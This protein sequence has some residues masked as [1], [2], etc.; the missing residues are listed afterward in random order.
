M[1]G[2]SVLFNK[3][4][5]TKENYID[6]LCSLKKINHRG[7]DDEGIVLIN[8]NTNDF[9]IIKNDLTLLSSDCVSDISSINIENYNLI[10]GHKR[11]SIIDL[12]SQ[13]H[14]PMQGVDGSW[15]VFNGEIYNYIELKEE[16][17]QY[18]CQFHTHSDTEVVL[19]AYRIWGKE[20]LNKFN[21]MW[22]ICIWDAPQKKLFINNDRFGVKP[23]Y[24][25]EH[26]NGF[27]LVSELKQFQGFNSVSLVLNKNHIEEFT[28]YGF[29]DV[30][31]N[32]MYENISRFKKSHYL[33]IDPLQYFNQDI[34][35]KQIPYYW[36]KKVAVEISEKEAIEQFRS[37]L[38]D[39]VR[40]RMRADVD[41]GFALSGGI[42][43]S[44]VLYMARNI[45]KDNNMMNELLGF[46]AV[47]PGYDD[48]DESKFVKIV[49]QDLPCK[50][51]YSKA[52]DEFNFDSFE[53]HIYHQDEPLQGTTY[54]AQWSIYKKAKEAGVKVLFNGQ[55]ADEVFAGYHHHFYRH[56]R[57]LIM[58]G[59]IPQYFSLV[60]QYAD[61]KNISKKQ[62][63]KTVFDEL[64]LVSK[65]KLGIAKFD[66]ALLKYWN[67]IE[68]LDEMLL[69]DFDTFQLPLFLRADDRDSMAFSIE[70]RHPF[71]DY[72][73]VEFGYSLPN[74]LLIKEG[75]QKYIIRKSMHEMPESVRYRKDKKGFVTPEDVWLKKHKSEF[76]Q[77]LY[78]NEK[79]LGVKEPSS[80][81]FYNYALGTWF[82]VN[83]F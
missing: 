35:L 21:G 23:L 54:F 53:R 10:L 47:F 70:S 26:D 37:L 11:L 28:Q 1:C 73:L 46:S 61:L 60:Q 56:C 24:Y 32:S 27:N 30:D 5:V 51:Y 6:F 59:K 74:D 36:L 8:T 58:M 3:H 40:I 78:Y 77:Y 39:S 20:C 17:K 69:R 16:L 72:R 25:F 41:F 33:V 22:T 50:T 19:E 13:G 75:W 18:G 68:T 4:K 81:P 67:K 15:I 44:S 45:L 57:Q 80:N 83:H 49:E 48:V 9:R 34:K 79:V 64:K 2:I 82:K 62:I 38:Y 63:H 55:G 76:D 12:T 29:L 66:H 31:E 14:Q 65:M 52:M 43:S 42:D 7:P 71:M